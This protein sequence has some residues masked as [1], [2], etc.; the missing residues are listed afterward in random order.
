M[1][2]GLFRSA[3]ALLVAPGLAAAQATAP[4]ATPAGPPAKLAVAPAGEVKPQP[5]TPGDA[6]TAC[7]PEPAEPPPPCEPPGEDC[8]KPW[9]YCYWGR[10]EALVWSIKHSQVPPLVTL[11][12]PADVVPGGLGQPGTV[13]L[14]GGNIEN[15][16]RYGG[17]FTVGRWLSSEEI[18]GLEGSFLFL[19]KRSVRFDDSSTGQPILARPFVDAITGIQNAAFIS[20]PAVEAGGIHIDLSSKLWGAEANLRV[21]VGRRLSCHD[22]FRIDLLGGFRHLELDEGLSIAQAGVF[23]PTSGVTSV[24]AVNTFDQFDAR[25]FFYGAQ[26]GVD[27]ELI[28][29]CWSLKFTGKVAVGGNR[30]IVGIQGNRVA[31]APDG[32]ATVLPGGF[33]AQPT[34]IGRFSRAEFAVLPELGVTVGYQ[35]THR[36]RASVGYSVIYLSNAVRPGDQIDLTI[37][38]TLIPPIVGAFTPT[39]PPRPAFSFHETDFWAQGVTASLEFRY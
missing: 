13:I 23:L 12:S 3:L 15:E 29:D 22:S 19:D 24:A 36:L 16:E 2:N 18:V 11:G 27:A 9:P 33:L 1:K 10:A 34:N 17:R 32:T 35:V 4:A 26:A 28:H 21:E 39:G 5:P 14:F 8:N 7:E 37:N 38:T 20:V 6:L 25:N 30:E 31:L